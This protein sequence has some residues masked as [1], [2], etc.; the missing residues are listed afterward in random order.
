MEGNPEYDKEGK[1]KGVKYSIN[2][3]KFNW[4]CELF[5]VKSEDKLEAS[6]W[7]ALVAEEAN[8][9]YEKWAA[10]ERHARWG[11]MAAQMQKNKF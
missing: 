4:A 8:E 7:V 11:D 6:S 9:A 3:E 5:R 10:K 2:I 1:V